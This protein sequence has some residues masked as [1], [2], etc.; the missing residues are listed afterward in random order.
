MPPNKPAYMKC[1]EL[2]AFNKLTMRH[3]LK[4]SAAYLRGPP[5]NFQESIDKLRETG[6]VLV[7]TVPAE[8]V[9]PLPIDNV[10]TPEPRKLIEGMVREEIAQNPKVYEGKN[11]NELDVLFRRMLI[12]KLTKSVSE[13]PKQSIGKQMVAAKKLAKKP[14]S[15]PKFVVRAV[16]M[17]ESEDG[18][19]EAGDETS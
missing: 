6:N 14:S 12:D 2:F 3:V 17:S 8:V 11:A 9:A 15:K 10:P 1:P 7:M 13:P 4:T 18:E 16:Q 5:E 19:T